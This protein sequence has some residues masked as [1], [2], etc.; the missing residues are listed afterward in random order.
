MF[1]RFAL[2][3]GAFLLLVSS[4]QAMEK[5][6]MTLGLDFALPYILTVDGNDATTRGNFNV[7]VDGRYMMS[8]NW[9]LGTRIFFDVEKRGGS[10]R[11]FGIMPGTQYMWNTDGR[12]MPYLRGDIPIIFRGAI[13][14]TTT[15]SSSK[16]DVG[17]AG[18]AGIAWNL[19][20]AIGVEN[21]MLRYDFNFSYTFGMSSALPVFALEFFKIGIDYH[22]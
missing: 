12:W 10:N 4:A 1:K 3:L 16:Q 13:N 5:G 22:F 20:D 15:N 8:E 18:G 7:G 11:Q 17:I 19:G 9:N 6:N 14:N 21:M 2:V